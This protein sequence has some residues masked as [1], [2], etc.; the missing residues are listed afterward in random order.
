[1]RTA[2]SATARTDQLCGLHIVLQGFSH[3]CGPMAGIKGAVVAFPA[4]VG[5]GVFEADE[6]FIVHL[7]RQGGVRAVVVGVPTALGSSSHH[8]HVQQGVSVRGHQA[9]PAGFRFA[10]FSLPANAA[11]VLM[12]VCACVR[13]CMRGKK[14][15][16]CCDEDLPLV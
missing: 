1:M 15:R 3:A 6:L 4:H 7:R 14:Y 10:Q 9:G 11:Q 5:P 16:G 13:V 12:C 8:T 2:R